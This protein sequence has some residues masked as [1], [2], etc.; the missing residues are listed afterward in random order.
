MKHT[1]IFCIT[2]MFATMLFGAHEDEFIIGAYSQYQMHHANQ[3]EKVF[4]DLGRL[5]HNAGFNTVLYS[6]RY[7]GAEKGRLAK[8][9]QA[10]DKHGIYSI[11]D[12]WAW[13]KDSFIGATTMAH[14]NYL[15]MEAEYIYDYENKTFKVDKLPI[16]DSVNDKYNYVFKHDTGKRSPH[17]PK[18]L[19]N[20][21]A[22]ICDTRDKHPAGIA[23]SHPRF[24]WKQENRET[25]RTIGR[26][27]KF[28][29][30]SENK[31]YLRV[32]LSW[33]E[34]QQMD[35]VATISL[36][37]LKASAMDSKLG[38]Y[39][40]YDDSAYLSL[41]LKSLNPAL[42]TT[43]IV[44]KAYPGLPTDNDTGFYI[45]DF[46]ADM[47]QP[48]SD[49]FKQTM[50]EEYFYH[51]NPQVYW[52]GI[53]RL[54]I[55]Y[56]E[57][58]DEL[59]RALTSGL[60][61]NNP[62]LKRLQSRL[63]QIDKIDEKGNIL[64]FYAKDEP[65][66]GQF[67]T[68]KKLEQFLS[69][70]GKKLITATHLGSD[71]V[72]K[73]AGEKP[74]FHFGLFLQ[75]AKPAVVMLDAYALQ[76]WGAGAGT[77][78]RWNSDLNH[79]LFIQNKLETMVIGNY[80]LLASTIKGSDDYK[81][82]RLLF[83]PQTFGEKFN[84]P[85]SGEWR[86]F[87]PPRGMLKML[88]LLPLC[89]GADGVIDYAI[90]ANRETA[91][92][93]GNR[94]YIRVS[95]LSHEPNYLGLEA[96]EDEISM[97]ILGEANA[98][99]HVYGPLIRKLKWQSANTI[100]ISGTKFD[101]D[102][103]TFNLANI[104]VLSQ[105]NKDPYQGYVQCGYYKDAEGTPSFMLVNRRAVYKN[106]DAPA[107]VPNDVD[108]Y[109]TDA[110]PQIVRFSVSKKSAKGF[111]LY[112]P[113]TKRLYSA[114]NGSID[115][116]IGPGDGIFLQ[117]VETLPH[118]LR[119]DMRLDSESLVSGAVTIEKGKKI[120]FFPI[121]EVRFAKGSSVTIS[122]GAT[123][124]LN[125]KTSFEPRVRII[126]YPGAKLI[127]DPSKCVFAADTVIESRKNPSFFA[128]LFGAK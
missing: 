71:G 33:D 54:A 92:P 79:R 76:E 103:A 59:H 72:V 4:D 44:N 18:G 8:T 19:S 30:T 128:R 81:D 104:Q 68:Y 99:L 1:L 112:D 107:I 10:L 84:P 66:Q 26:D 106:A 121:S 89:Y 62:I 100:Q 93:H 25:S 119:K 22:W 109:F 36:K 94:T 24:R 95:P 31:L 115:V 105:N 88:Q 70:R 6:M 46:Y 37:V 125:G 80:H 28:Y 57:I 114:D 52:H 96:P 85:E 45:F 2:F 113:Y 91:F 111:A 127:H 126:L 3:T 27:F 73:P 60:R 13:E 102:P 82:T 75:E 117:M 58:E 39:G 86:Y 11:I 41:E 23:L 50:N 120:E 20:G 97:Q 124:I 61:S 116:E 77:L 21:Y 118:T 42:Y 15:R 7:E 83:V 51:I 108:N 35:K 69:Q 98:K 38:E 47:P 101:I 29:P 32:A 16:L 64:Y 56:I 12:D 5:L 34:I 110:S 53:G 63:D 14:G 17:D 55:D 122:N 78:I 87:M 49:I 40:I 90:T 74:Y 43:D 9:L 123:L 65:Y 67:A 48:G